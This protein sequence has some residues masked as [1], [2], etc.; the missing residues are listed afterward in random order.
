MQQQFD[1]FNSQATPTPKPAPVPAKTPA[2]SIPALNPTPCTTGIK[3]STKGWIFSPETLAELDQQL[4]KLVPG[5]KW[6]NG[7]GITST[8]LGRTKTNH[9]LHC[10]PVG[11]HV[12]IRINLDESPIKS[13]TNGRQ[14][15]MYQLDQSAHHKKPCYSPAIWFELDHN[16]WNGRG[17]QPLW[18]RDY[19]QKGGDIKK[20]TRSLDQH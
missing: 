3:F 15:P 6:I 7:A 2:A 20:I 9:L 19:L 18:V 13:Y 5:E 10:D 14:I 17:R 12:L 8:Y 11:E 1:L 4:S 16:T